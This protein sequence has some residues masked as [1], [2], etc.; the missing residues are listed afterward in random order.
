MIENEWRLRS[1]ATQ[2]MF[3]RNLEKLYPGSKYG[4][5]MPIEQWKWLRTSS[6]TCCADT[7][8]SGYRPDNQAIIVVGDIDVDR[9][10]QK[11]KEMFSSIKL[12]PNA[13]PVV[14]EPVPDNNEAIII[15]DK[16]KEQQTNIVQIMFKHDAIPDSLKSNPM[17][18]VQQYATNLGTQMLNARLGEGGPKP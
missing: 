9:T 15:I 14:A 10:E 16:D 7:T 3:E 6:R 8:T 5:R 12:D 4:R 18:L 13:A 2:R 11:I 17:Y 1:S